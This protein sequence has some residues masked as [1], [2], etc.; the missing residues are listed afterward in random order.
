MSSQ[1]MCSTHRGDSVGS[2]LLVT[3]SYRS[4]TTLIE[5]LLHTHDNICLGSQ[6]FPILYFHVKKAF[7]DSIQVERRY[8]L[9]HLFLENSYAPE[10]L[11]DFLDRHILTQSALS[12]I[13]DELADYLT[14]L[15]TP[16]ILRFREA[17][18]PGTFL[19]VCHQLNEAIT[20][21][22]PKPHLLYSGS[23]EIMCEEF[24]PYLLSHNTH[25]VL[26]IRDPR[27]MMASLS[28]RKR[29]NRTGR[30]RPILYSLRAWRKSVAF[31]LH[32][33]QNP[34]ATWIRY[35]DLVKDPLLVLNQILTQLGLPAFSPDAFREGIR[36]Q[37]GTLWRGNSSFQD[38]SGLS[39]APVGESRDLLPESVLHYIESCCRP[40][41]KR[42][43]YSFY[44]GSSFDEEVVRSFREPFP[45]S[46]EKFPADYSWSGSHPEE[47]IERY[48]FLS[49][50]DGHLSD[51]DKRRWF[52]FNDVYD[53]LHSAVVTESSS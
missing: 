49:H 3:G 6:P 39:E 44:C 17:L 29:D 5:K 31:A 41:M 32:H 48:R 52:L 12:Q 38:F 8:P 14:G 10:D 45:V 53:K 7:L 27:D 2:H 43:G 25:I 50:P 18:S 42:M 34:N 21:L 36:D 22:F 20:Q 33:D 19:S 11:A 13:F 28:F 46:H 23:K 26:I 40:E 1:P 16:E 9:D 15:W 35:E 47:E 24:M 37:R 4:G 51:V 30:N